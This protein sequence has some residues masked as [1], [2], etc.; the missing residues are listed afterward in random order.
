MKNSDTYLSLWPLTDQAWQTGHLGHAL[1]VEGNPS[2]AYDLGLALS[3][4]L[5]CEAQGDRTCSCRSCSHEITQHPDVMRIQPEKERIRRQALQMILQ[6]VNRP[7]LWSPRLVIWIEE[8]HR[9]TDAAQSYLLKSL[10]EPPS[11]LVFILTTDQSHALL[12]TVKSRCQLLRAE[13]DLLDLAK[14]FDPEQFFQGKELTR[15]AIIRFSYWARSFYRHRQ[16]PSWLALWE[17][18]YQAYRHVNANGAQE[19]AK[20]IL[21]NAYDHVHQ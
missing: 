1:I 20:E 11:F 7:P 21:R 9:L 18:G 10:E 12:A 5:V 4:Q 16:N 13:P 2:K 15:D 19:L 3:R 17:A 6:N 14:D 8:A